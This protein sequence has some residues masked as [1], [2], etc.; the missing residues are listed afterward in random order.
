MRN[1]ALSIVLFFSQASA[2]AAIKYIQMPGGY[3][4]AVDYAKAQPGKPTVILING[5]V[6]ETARWEDL[7]KPLEQKGYGVLRYYFRGQILS[8]KKEV[9][10]SGRPAFFDTGLETKD[11]A[12]ELGQ[13]LTLF[14]IK[15]AHVV[16]L[17]YGATIAAEFAKL[18]PARVDQLVLM[19]PYVVAMDKLDP[20][21]Q[22]LR[23]NLDA[24]R[25]YWG[26]L[27]GPYAFDYYYNLIYRD[28]IKGRITPDRIP[29]A[30]ANI[31]EEYK[32]SV[33]HLVRAARDFDLETLKL[34]HASI[35][36]MV[37]SKEDP[38]L[39]R[40]Q[41]LSWKTFAPKTKGSFIYLTPAEH[42]I[43]DSS[44]QAAE[45]WLEQVI[46]GDSQT[47]NSQ[48]YYWNTKQSPQSMSFDELVKKIGVK[49]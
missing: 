1:F 34:S 42:A 38:A 41:F 13:L 30:V 40:E 6:Y 25:T 16:G 48:V 32:E 26:P 33:F 49:L 19:S 23:W 8:L 36:M 9:E 18:Y 4:L 47:K 5:L 46:T 2:F 27:W 15:R 11:F 44:S 22:W 12:K 17:S 45:A 28:Y 7:A 37:A 14:K 20:Q 39:Q 29:S 31:P 21:G 10:Q 35:H 3:P 43:P 24:L